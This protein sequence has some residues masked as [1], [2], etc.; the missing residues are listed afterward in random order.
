MGDKKVELMWY[1]FCLFRAII[2]LFSFV[3]VALLG[4]WLLRGIPWRGVKRRPVK[5]AVVH[6][7][8]TM[9]PPRNFDASQSKAIDHRPS[10]RKK[11]IIPPNTAR[12]A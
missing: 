3:A 9:R 6:P 8:G 12:P 4:K 11:R 5:Y 2:L 10:V 7:L 1:A